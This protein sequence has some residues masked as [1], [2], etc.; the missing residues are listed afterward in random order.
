MLWHSD[1]CVLLPCSNAQ[2]DIFVVMNS[3]VVGLPVFS[4]DIRTW[5]PDIFVYIQCQARRLDYSPF[6]LDNLQKLYYL[7]KGG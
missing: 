3:C 4:S 5:S 6:E 7:R 2:P 1:E